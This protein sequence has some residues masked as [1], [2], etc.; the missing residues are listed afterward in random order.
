M[1]LLCDCR[2][3]SIIVILALLLVVLFSILFYRMNKEIEDCGCDNK[4]NT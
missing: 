3:I 2:T 4:V 1:N